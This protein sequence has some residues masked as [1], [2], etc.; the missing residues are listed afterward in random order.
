VKFSKTNGR[1]IPL[2]TCDGWTFDDF[3][4]TAQQ[5]TVEGQQWGAL[6]YDDTGYEQTFLVNGGVPDGR[7][8][9]DGLEFTMA[10]EQGIGVVQWIADLTCVH[11]VQPEWALLQVANAGNQLFVSGQV[12]MIFRTFGTTT[13]FRNNIT[14]FVWDIGPV[15]CREAQTC[16]TSM[17]V[18]ASPKSTQNG[19][20]A[21]DLY[22]FLNSLDGGT[23][24]AENSAFV[25]ARKAAADRLEAGDQPPANVKLFLDAA[26]NSTNVNFSNYTSRT[27]SVYRPQMELVWTCQD[28][29]ENVLTAVK[30][31]VESVLAGN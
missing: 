22:Y 28:T 11:R 29:A 16:E 26:E 10:S 5:L 24:F 21:W 19:D 4:E 1:G 14:D 12:A 7:F 25:P 15:P 18:F 20:T 31:E 17:I 2:W 30:P 13:Y 27:R 23:I 6:I 9:K 8:S 3:L